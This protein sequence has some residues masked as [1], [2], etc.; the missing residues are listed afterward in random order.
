[1]SGGFR[2]SEDMETAT[3]IRPGQLVLTQDGNERI[4]AVLEMPSPFGEGWV[5]VLWEH[6]LIQDERIPD[7][8]PV[9]WH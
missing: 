5:R 4:G 8:T 1:M 6:A 9:E 7:L 2:Y 3:T